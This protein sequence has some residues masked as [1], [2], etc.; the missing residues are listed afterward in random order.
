[1]VEMMSEK[2]E[3]LGR[4]VRSRS[5]VLFSQRH[6]KW[7]FRVNFIVA[8]V[9]GTGSLATI[10]TILAIHGPREVLLGT[11]GPSIAAIVNFVV[12]ATLRRK[13]SSSVSSSWQL[14]NEGRA[15][16]WQI[17]WRFLRDWATRAPRGDWVYRINSRIQ[18][19]TLA[20]LDEAAFAYNRILGSLQPG[21]SVAISAHV[22]SNA[23]TA[24]DE[25]M[26]AI[27]N[28]AALL[29]R[30]P[31]SGK[32]H[33]DAI[34]KQV[35]LLN[36]LGDRVASLGAGRSDSQGASVSGSMQRVLD[37]LRLEQLARSELHGDDLPRQLDNRQL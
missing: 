28:S 24:A 5:S 8:G 35:E 19:E 7:S 26:C 6:G 30:Y 12:G 23:Q 10:I 25:S 11:I 4:F 16:A 34:S 2:Y 3:S 9:L 1:M 22:A 21:T 32:A 37:E 13:F 14:T 27:L 18:D 33:R 29:D 17:H 20:I 31:E 36:E 15:L